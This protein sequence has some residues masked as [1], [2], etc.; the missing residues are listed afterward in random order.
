M[1]PDQHGFTGPTAARERIIAIV[2]VGTL[3][4]AKSRLGETLDA[5]E[6]RDLVTAL[7]RR[8]IDAALGTPAIAETIVI[9]PDDEVLAIALAGGARAIR[10]HGH[11]LNRSLREARADAVAG[12]A[13]AVLVLPVDLLPGIEDCRPALQFACRQRLRPEPYAS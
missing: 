1:N 6:R 11:G 8:T 5:E 7:L 4:G 2:P 3:E 9:T 12:G 10:Q 13:S